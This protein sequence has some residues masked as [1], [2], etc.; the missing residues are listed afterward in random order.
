MNDDEGHRPPGMAEC[1]ECK[2][3]GGGV[4]AHSLSD[5]ASLTGV[6]KRQDILGCGAGEMEQLGV[7]AASREPVL[8]PTPRSYAYNNLELQL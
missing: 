7:L 4:F 3:Q 2:G 5:S 1:L 6:D 8:F